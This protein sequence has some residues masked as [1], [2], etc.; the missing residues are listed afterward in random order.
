[1]KF[2]IIRL[3]FLILLTKLSVGVAGDSLEINKIVEP[4]ISLTSYL[5]ILEDSSQKLTLADVHKRVL[6][7]ILKPIFHRKN[8]LI[9]PTHPQLIGCD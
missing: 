9:Y 3:F 4:S 7:A 8:L 2:I 5:A 1:M 6:V